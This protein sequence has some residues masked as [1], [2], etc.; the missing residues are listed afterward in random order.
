MIASSKRL[1]ALEKRIAVLEGFVDKAPVRMYGESPI[2]T[3]RRLMREV[4]ATAAAYDAQIHAAAQRGNDPLAPGTRVAYQHR[5][6]RKPPTWFG[7]VIARPD[8]APTFGRTGARFVW[9][10]RDG[11]YTPVGAYAENLWRL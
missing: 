3:A 11:S 1:T 10:V 4:E 7:T 2:A 9:V 5:D 8:R 6:S